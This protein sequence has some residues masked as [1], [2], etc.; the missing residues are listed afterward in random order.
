VKKGKR[1]WKAVYKKNQSYLYGEKM[2][3]S[4]SKNKK[5]NQ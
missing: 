2:R 5:A 1:A 3:G 4:H